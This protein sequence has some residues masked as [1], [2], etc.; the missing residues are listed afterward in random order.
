MH[1]DDDPTNC[2]SGIRIIDLTQFE[3]GPACTKV[4]AW[5]GADVVKLENP[6]SGDPGRTLG[7][8]PGA[9]GWSFM[10]FN[11][12]KKSMTV[13]LKFAQGL[14][15][16]KQLAAKADVFVESFAPGTIEKLGLGYE[17][18]IPLNPRLIYAQVK[19]F[20][21]GSPYENYLAFDSIG[22]ACG[23]AMSVTGESDGPPIKPGP[24]LGDTGTGMLL[25]I[26]ILGALHRRRD[27]NRGAHLK[28]A[29][30]DAVMQYI[31]GGF[32]ASARSGQPAPRF[33]DRS[34]SAVNF[35][36]GLFPTKPGGPNDYIYL[37]PSRANPEHWTRL[38]RVLGR[39]DLIG[40]PRYDTLEARNE[41][42][43][44]V[45]EIVTSWTRGME[46]REAMKR[47]G[48]AGVPVGAVYDTLELQ[49]DPNLMDRGMMQTVNHPVGGPFQMPGWPASFDGKTVVVTPAPTLGANTKEVLEQW[50]GFDDTD[51]ERL[52]GTNVL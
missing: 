5:L 3:A 43:A 49:S 28:V 18:L 45:R 48:D 52:T 17:A 26:S 21:T 6:L 51:I 38:L 35:P 23:G 10:N 22:Q 14:D 8:P 29:M 2:L 37:F 27:T 41:N 19:G 4:L 9:D 30:Q 31:R 47:I 40:D 33:G 1:N 24:T 25:A 7:A 50:L 39:E 42:E 36:V 32:A 16:A 11:A 12:N 13:D 20:A 34:A 15:L 46:K 44:E